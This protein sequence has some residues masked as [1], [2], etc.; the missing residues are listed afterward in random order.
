[1]GVYVRQDNVDGPYVLNH[2]G[3]ATLV[4]SAPTFYTF[5][6]KFVPGYAW[7]LAAAPAP[8]RNFGKISRA[9]ANDVRHLL[10]GTLDAR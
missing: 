3:A 10:N 4:R 1:M 9:A 8:E 7:A 2:N 6:E 5:V